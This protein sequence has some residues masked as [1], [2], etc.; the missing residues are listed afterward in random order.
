MATEK[1]CQKRLEFIIDFVCNLAG[2]RNL[3]G[4]IG[5]AYCLKFWIIYLTMRK[6]ICFQVISRISP[7]WKLFASCLHC[8]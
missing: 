6:L 8:C 5:Y 7:S 2:Y 3:D 1:V 4:S